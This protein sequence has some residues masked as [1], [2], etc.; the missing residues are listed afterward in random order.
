MIRRI[1]EITTC[2]KMNAEK[3]TG[4]P[5]I[6]KRVQRCQKLFW[7]FMSLEKRIQKGSPKEHDTV[8]WSESKFQIP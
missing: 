2:I 5:Q 6:H 3:K 8:S 7:H 1:G 4:M